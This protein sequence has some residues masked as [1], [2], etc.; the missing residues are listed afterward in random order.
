MTILMM[1]YLIK[2]Q[3]DP[4]VKGGFPESALVVYKFYGWLIWVY[5]VA[6][7]V[8]L[9]VLVLREIDV[10]WDIAPIMGMVFL[11]WI[12]TVS[13]YAPGSSF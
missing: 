8:V 3:E 6:R 5:M 10:R 2:L 13:P 11:Q 4:I 12:M 9:G 1:S 7:T